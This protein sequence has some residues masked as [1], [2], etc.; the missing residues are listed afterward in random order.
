MAWLIRSLVIALQE[1]IETGGLKP[2]VYCSS[3]EIVA[4]AWRGKMAAINGQ[5]NSYRAFLSLN[6]YTYQ[7]KLVYKMAAINGQRNSCRVF[8]SL[9]FYTY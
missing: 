9:N 5:R 7:P 6:F 1:T 4:V 8:L 2:S 3:R